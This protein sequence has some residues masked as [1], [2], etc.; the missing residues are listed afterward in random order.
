MPAVHEDWADWVVRTTKLDPLAVWV[1]REAPEVSQSQHQLLAAVRAEL[2][3]R[4]GPWK[5]EVAEQQLNLSH[6]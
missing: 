2:E 1:A 4:Q 3:A 6:S 5:R